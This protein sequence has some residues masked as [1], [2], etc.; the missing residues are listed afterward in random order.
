M[1]NTNTNALSRL[2]EL[3]LVVAT[4]RTDVEVQLVEDRLSLPVANKDTFQDMAQFN[5]SDAVEVKVVRGD[6]NALDQLGKSPKMSFSC[7]VG[8]RPGY[9]VRIVISLIVS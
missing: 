8:R 1:R 7:Y 4:E 9:F 6:I 2:Q 5:L 3:S